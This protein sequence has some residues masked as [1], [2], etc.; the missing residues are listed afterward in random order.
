MLYASKFGMIWHIAIVLDINQSLNR[1]LPNYSWGNWDPE[2]LANLSMVLNWWQKA[3][4]RNQFSDP[5]TIA[6]SFLIYDNELRKFLY[7]YVQSPNN[8][9]SSHN[10]I[11]IE[12]LFPL[13]IK[14][15]SQSPWQYKQQQK[16]LTVAL[17]VWSLQL[18]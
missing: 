4:L 16:K 15:V 7:N 9:L 8:S 13:I 2:K 18:L 10:F 17:H 12:A 11:L 14:W 5:Q 3:R 1:I 6:F